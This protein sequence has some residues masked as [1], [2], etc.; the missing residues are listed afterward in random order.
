MYSP[1]LQTLSYVNQR[2]HGRVGKVRSSGAPVNVSQ[3]LP[4]ACYLLKVP[5]ILTAQRM[6][7]IVFGLFISFQILPLNCP[8]LVRG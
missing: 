7:T 3:M 6:S 8:E 2:L 4:T 5:L 1:G